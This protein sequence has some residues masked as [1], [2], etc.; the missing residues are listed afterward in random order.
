MSRACTLLF[1]AVL[2]SV[3]PARAMAQEVYG[4]VFAHGV[5]TPF[6]IDTGERGVNLQAG[7]RFE[8]IDALG[9]AQ[10][11]VFGSVNLSGNTSFI[12]GGVGWKFDLG[13]DVY[14]RPGMGMI[15]HDGPERRINREII[16]RTDLGSRVLLAP[17]IAVGVKLDDRWSVEASWIHMSHAGLF[18]DEQNPGIDTIGVRVNWRM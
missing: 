8:E 3:L 13:D 16:R 10:P 18:D 9:D 1:L 17:E 14:V 4:G 15:V 6:T 2:A 11:Y 5:N 7:I 12:G